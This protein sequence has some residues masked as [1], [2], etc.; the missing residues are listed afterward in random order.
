MDL[1]ASPFLAIPHSRF[2][3]LKFEVFLRRFNDLPQQFFKIEFNSA[4]MGLHNT[5]FQANHV[6]LL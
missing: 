5:S 6:Y 4:N 3:L 2:T 1:D